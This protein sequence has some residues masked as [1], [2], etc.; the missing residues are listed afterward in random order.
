MVKVKIYKANDSDVTRNSACLPICLPFC[1]GKVI[2][3]VK[4]S[5][6]QLLKGTLRSNEEKLKVKQSNE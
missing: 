3:K 5:N 4:S 6:E 2:G 1:L